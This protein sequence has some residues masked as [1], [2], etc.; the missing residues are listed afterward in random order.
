MLFIMNALLT[1][2]KAKIS[3]DH[4]AGVKNCR[5]PPLGMVWLGAGEAWSW[6]FRN[7]KVLAPVL[8]REEEVG[9]SLGGVVWASA[10]KYNGIFYIALLSFS[11]AE[12]T[13]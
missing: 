5:V 6:S 3:S 11:F 12:Q 7:T 8:V 9:L 1:K 2:G 10:S 4:E 13:C